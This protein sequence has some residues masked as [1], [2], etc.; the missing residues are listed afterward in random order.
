MHRQPAAVSWP[1]RTARLSIRRATEDDLE[2]TWAVPPA[3]RGLRVADPRA[4]R[5]GG[6]HR[7]VPRPRTR[8]AKTLIVERDGEVIGDLMFAVEDAWAQDEVEEQAKGTQAE[9]GWVIAPEHTG[10]GYATEA[11]AELLRISF[12]DLGLR[13]VIAQCFADN[14]RVLEADGAARDAPGGA[15]RARSRCTA[16]GVARQPRVRHPRRGVAQL[17]VRRKGA[18]APGPERGRTGRCAPSGSPSA[19]RRR[20]TPTRCSTSAACP[21]SPSGCRSCRPTGRRGRSGS[22]TPTGWR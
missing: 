2:A 10:Q 5:P 16:R 13:R 14:V 4:V 20:R 9:L 1:L 19:P 15:R 6:L 3:A 17:D 18:D 7:A 22:P 11:A 12:E 21:R 8:L